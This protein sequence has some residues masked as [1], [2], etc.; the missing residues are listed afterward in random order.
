MVSYAHM[1]DAEIKE[2]REKSIK[3]VKEKEERWKKKCPNGVDP[4]CRTPL[5]EPHHIPY[6]IR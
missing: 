3:D 1:T 6:P 2:Y 4:S 5:D